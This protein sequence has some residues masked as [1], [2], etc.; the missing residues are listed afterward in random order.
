MNME[1]PQATKITQ[2]PLLTRGFGLPIC[3]ITSSKPWERSIR[4]S[5]SGR[6]S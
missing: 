2:K 5:K 6:A 3:V 4:S 1:D